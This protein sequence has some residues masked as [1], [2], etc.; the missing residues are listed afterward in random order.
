MEH[1]YIKFSN[2]YTHDDFNITK[3]WLADLALFTGSNVMRAIDNTL[4]DI[5]AE[6]VWAET[7]AKAESHL[8]DAV[9]YLQGVMDVVEDSTVL[10]RIVGYMYDALALAEIVPYADRLN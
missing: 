7:K 9:I 1:W 5:L 6:S 3:G 10:S 4:N 2:G 8:H